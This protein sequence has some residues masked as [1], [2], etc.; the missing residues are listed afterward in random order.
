MSEPL[1]RDMS[2]VEYFKELVEAA[3]DRQRLEAGALTAF[4][5]V[6]LLNGFVHLDRNE[7]G[8]GDEPL[9]FK[10]GRALEA[11]PAQQRASLKRVGDLSLFISGYFSESL[12]RKVVDVDYYVAVGE[13]A[14]A[15]LS[16]MDDDRWA[17]VFGELSARFVV[18]MDVLS[19]VSERSGLASN[20]DLLRLYEKWLRTG[21]RRNGQLLVE[22]GIVPNASIGSRFVQ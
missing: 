7:D 6:N 17:T 15:S 9:A 8:F 4:Y 13:Y 3:I 22:R 18:Y 19:E 5:L 10:L 12:S 21:S 1:F 11:G 14:Y 16:R 2:A 20:T